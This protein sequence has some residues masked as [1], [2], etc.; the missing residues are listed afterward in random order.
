M[1]FQERPGTYSAPEFAGQLVE[2]GA[3]LVLALAQ[4]QCRAAWSCAGFGDFARGLR[5]SRSAMTFVAGAVQAVEAVLARAAVFHQAGLLELGEMR[6]NL[7]LAHARIS[8]SSATESSSCSSS[9]RMRSRLGSATAAGIS[10]LTPWRLILYH[11][12][13]IIDM[14]DMKK[15]N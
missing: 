14:I 3:D 13:D 5:S 15:E 6:R 12:N 4:R 2:K 1:P 11:I 8:C 9:S 10:G 7:A